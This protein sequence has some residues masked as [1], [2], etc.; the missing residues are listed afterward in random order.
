LKS[1]PV[2]PKSVGPASRRIDGDDAVRDV[3]EL[4]RFNYDRFV[5]K[6]ATA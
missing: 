5:E 4:L 3:V 6:R 1:F 2:F